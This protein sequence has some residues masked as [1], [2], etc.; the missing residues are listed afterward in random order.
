MK[1]FTKF[2]FIAFLLALS[3]TFTA[4]DD[5]D[6]EVV[7]EEEVITTVNVTLTPQGGGTAVVLTY[8]DSDGDGLNAVING[9]TLMANTPY[10]GSIEVLDETDPNDVE[11]ITE[12]IEEEDDE[13]QFFY[14][15]TNNIATATY[16][17]MDG[18]GNP[19]GLA[20]TLTTDNAGTG[21]FTLT[22]KHEPMKSAA[23]VS[24]GDPT[25]AGGETDVSITFPITVN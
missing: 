6:P 20:F 2:K 11:D 9:G 1:K 8:F 10:A 3:L 22:L 24:G 7:N 18:N 16:N 15:F 23:G 14:A 5:D 12:E 4:C 25:N 19:V 13:H 17:D 21:D